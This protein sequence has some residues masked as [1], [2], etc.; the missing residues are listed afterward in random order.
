MPLAPPVGAVKVTSTPATGLSCLS[1]TV[2]ASGIG[3]RPPTPVDSVAAAPAVTASG[4]PARLSS[5]MLAVALLPVT[6]AVAVN[7]PA[8]VFASKRGEVAI[9]DALVVAVAWVL[10]PGKLAPA[11]PEPVPPAPADPPPAA[12]SVKVTVWPCSGLPCP[13]STL[14]SSGWL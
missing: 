4:V 5:W 11:L 14:T 2:T 8:V 3:K 9:P 10:P 6:A 7:V 1:V 13:S 12:P